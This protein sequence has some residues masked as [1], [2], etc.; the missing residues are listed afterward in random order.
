[1]EVAAHD[2]P[3]QAGGH[4]VVLQGHAAGGHHD[5]LA[6]QGH[7]RPSRVVEPGDVPRPLL[8]AEEV[9]DVRVEEREGRGPVGGAQGAHGVLRPHRTYRATA[10]A[11]FSSTMSTVTRFM[12][13]RYACST[14]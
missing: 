9:G 6:F 2:P 5:S 12:P 4:A 3:A 14:G 10:S 7:R 8:L 11:T 13:S 1:M